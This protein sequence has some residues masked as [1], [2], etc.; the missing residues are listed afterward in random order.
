[1]GNSRR[2]RSIPDFSLIRSIITQ[3][4]HNQIPP[5]VR[6]ILRQAQ[7][8]APCMASLSNHHD[9]VKGAKRGVKNLQKKKDF[10][11]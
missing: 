3:Q 9:E 11:W 7:D 8:V 1:M 6:P 5:I 2:I 10:T 4:S